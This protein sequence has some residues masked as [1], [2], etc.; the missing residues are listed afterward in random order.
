M[1]LVRLDKDNKSTDEVSVWYSEYNQDGLKADLRKIECTSGKEDISSWKKFR[2]EVSSTRRGQVDK[3]AFQKGGSI[4][5]FQYREI[6][7]TK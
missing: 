2:V 1:T 5:A 7:V 6:I 3:K 4:V